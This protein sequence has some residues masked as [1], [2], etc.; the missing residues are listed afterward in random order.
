[1]RKPLTSSLWPQRR[2]ALLQG[3][4]VTESDRRHGLGRLLMEAAHRWAREQGATEMETEVWEFPEGPPDF[5]AGLGYTTR[6]R[7]LVR[8]LQP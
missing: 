1:M 4:A 2:Y 8:P 3:L 6:K 7:R 5:Y